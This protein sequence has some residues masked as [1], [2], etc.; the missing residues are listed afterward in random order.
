VGGR[1]APHGVP[2]GLVLT[3]CKAAS[4]S[5]VPL[6]LAQARVIEIKANCLELASQAR[7]LNVVAQRQA[8]AARPTRRGR[9]CYL[10][11]SWI[12]PRR[13]GSSRLR[14]RSCPSTRLRALLRRP[15]H[16]GS[17]NFSPKISRVP[18]PAGSNLRHSHTGGGRYLKYRPLPC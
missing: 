16:S 13:S 17:P 11:A 5:M 3:Q 18:I 10:L 9:A 1:S 8:L 2:V 7:W 12:L 6:F 4:P 14:R 15:F